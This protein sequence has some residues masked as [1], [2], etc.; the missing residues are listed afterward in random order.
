MEIWKTVKNFEDYEV[1]SLGRVKSLKLGKEKILKPCK[2]G[3]GYLMVGL[4]VNSK[5]TAKSIHQLVA[6][7][8]L[9]HT[10]CGFKLVVD[11]INDIKTDNRSENLQIVTPRFNSRKTQGKDTSNYK[12]VCWIK[13]RKKWR[14]QIRING[15]VKI[16]GHFVLELEAAEAYQLE[17]SKVL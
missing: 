8:F 10:P 2:M 14:S 11:H 12:G 17:L 5:V 15:K 13:A 1:S 16:L 4:C 6:I 9:N 7:S 3:K